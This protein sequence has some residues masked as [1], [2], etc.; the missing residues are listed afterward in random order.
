[1]SNLSPVSTG[2]ILRETDFPEGDNSMDGLRPLVYLCTL[3]LLLSACSKQAGKVSEVT[4]SFDSVKCRTSSAIETEFIVQWEDG[5]FSVEKGVDPETFRNEFVAPQVEQIKHVQI[6]QK[7]QMDQ[8]VFEAASEVPGQPADNWGQTLVNAN[9]VWSQGFKGQNIKVAV[10]DSVV[11]VNHPQLKT[12]IAVNSGEIPDNSKD[13]DQNGVVDDYFGATFFSAAASTQTNDHGSHVAGIIAADSTQGPM[14]GIAPQAQII[15]AS[16]LDG[17]GSGT[18]GDAVLAVQ[19][20]T[21][22]GAKI[23]NASW[24]GT[25]CS[26]SL[27]NAFT[28]ITR[29]GVLLVVAAG[30]SGADID[31]TSFYP[32]I[33][34]LAGQITVSASDFNDWVPAWSNTGFRNA[35][36]TAPGV[37]ILST[38]FGGKYVTMD[39]T[40][41][42]APFVA[43]A[44][45]VLWSAKPNA[46]NLQ[47]R[48]AI[49]RG[50]DVVAGKNS[51]TLSRGRLNLQKSLDELRRLVP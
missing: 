43:G 32:A 31:V 16:F 40:S 14:S 4:S 25:G 28:E 44:A 49:L 22:R 51:K 48:E 35:H 17:S 1:M 45:A 10:I 3:S 42:A 13:D 23:V 38:G 7:L 39:G 41:M 5:T 12:R 20:A 6:N 29:K 21:S 18:L 34:N 11:D 24:G 27:G 30:N 47:I 15:P 8:P 19:Y 46:S 9:A 2:L 50:V 26:D 33:Y 36:L 37:S